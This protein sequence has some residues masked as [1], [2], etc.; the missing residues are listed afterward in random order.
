MERK[1]INPDNVRID[2]EFSNVFGKLD[3][4]TEAALRQS[5]VQGFDVSKGKITVWFEP[6]NDIPVI[7]DGH[8]R[9][10]ICREHGVN[11]T[12]ACF[13][14]KAFNN[15]NEVIGWILNT[16]ISRRNLTDVE[17]VEL[18]ERFRPF[19]TARGKVNMSEGGKG[20]SISSKVDT[21]R[22]CAQMAGV[23]E[24]K[25]SEIRRVLD[26]DDEETKQKLR[27]GEMSA[28]AAAKKVKKQNGD[29][30][31]DG[32]DGGK[33]R[34]NMQQMAQID[35]KIQ[36]LNVQREQLY[37]ENCQI[38]CRMH[39]STMHYLWVEGTDV[40]SIYLEH[41]G[42][43]AI[44][45]LGDNVGD[46]PEEDQM[47]NCPTGRREEF[48]SIWKKAK[49]E[50]DQR[51]NAHEKEGYEGDSTGGTDGDRGNSYE[52]DSES[53]KAVRDI[54]SISLEFRK[55]VGKVIARHFHEDNGHTTEESQC[56]NA[57]Y[58]FLI[59]V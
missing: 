30:E 33:I 45:Y 15:R 17:R 1:W 14:E 27:S 26:S 54:R 47:S 52:A 22:E 10:R 58:K 13:T 34:K 39:D 16:Q 8:N 41:S 38:V 32:G 48:R 40:L 42:F 3:K 31:P 23:S 11:L 29:D 37:Q 20:S 59:A 5:L 25:Y 12:S 18:V 53:Q 55:K 21:R 9:F 6:G 56:A 35:H 44:I 51:R 50:M 19:F 2:E 28:H 49:E 43:R 36:S 7:I 24:G 46:L 57:I 4:E